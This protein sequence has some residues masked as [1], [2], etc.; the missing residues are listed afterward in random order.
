M[1][2]FLD[3]IKGSNR[4]RM[5]FFASIVC[6]MIF[7][8]LVSHYINVQREESLKKAE[9]A[10]IDSHIEVKGQSIYIGGEEVYRFLPVSGGTLS[11]YDSTEQRRRDI[12][13]R[14]FMLGEIPVSTRLQEYLFHGTVVSDT[15]AEFYFD[16]P[17]NNGTFANWNKFLEILNQK[18][19]HKFRLPTNDE[20][21][22]AARGGMS[23]QNYKYAGGNRI[24]EVAVYR[25]NCKGLGSFMC[26]DKRPN[27]LGFYDM[28]GCIWE[29]TSTNIQDFFKE[30]K[31][32]NRVFSKGENNGIAEFSE[33]HIARGGSYDSSAEECELNYI[34]HKSIMLTGARLV[35][36][37]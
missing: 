27:E 7:F 21:E 9:S 37:Y 11:V 17:A 33:S 32:Y 36:D 12:T 1:K 10:K 30:Y 15:C 22:Y 31:T 35:M 6:A 16:F 5:L 19:G 2:F 28:S 34:P 24:E 26:R 3:W 18:T 14:S 20:W 4:N 13:V 8:N 25:D 23:S 29:I